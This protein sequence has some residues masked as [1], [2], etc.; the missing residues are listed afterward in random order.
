MLKLKLPRSLAWIA[1]LFLCVCAGGPARIAAQTGNDLEE[2]KKQVI[3]LI[4]EVKYTDALPLLE[5]IVAVE[6]QNA[7]MQFYLGFSLTANALQLKDEAASRALRVRARAAFVK[8]K[9]L[10]I[11]E[12]IIDGLIQSIP[13]DGSRSRSYSSNVEA[14]AL[15]VVA[16]ADFAKGKLDDAFSKYQQAL[17]LDPKLYHAALFSGD[18]YTHREDF[19]QAEAWYQKAIAINP[20]IETAYRYSATPLM[21]Q[22]KIQEARD[23]YIEA[24]ITEPYSNFALAGLVRWAELTKTP[25]RHPPIEIPTSVTFDDKGNAKVNLDPEGIKGKDDGSFA[26]VGYGLQRTVWRKEKFAKTYPNETAY[27]HSLAE[28]ADALRTVVKMASTS[29]QV[30]TLTP[31]LTLLKKLDDDGLL[32]AYILLARPNEGIGKDYFQY[33]QTN[34]AKLIRYMKEYVVGRTGK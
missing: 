31:S 10:G 13:S 17:K 15:M 9:E 1:I 29:D 32:E 30:K 12:P 33:L 34:R 22:G 2:L 14:N 24:F 23:R 21:R 20:M 18:V 26:W 4:D 3:K 27:R 11:N 25:M 5:K 7:R 19:A 16:E 6:P 28:E 8:A